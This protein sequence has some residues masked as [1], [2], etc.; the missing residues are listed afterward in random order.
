MAQE[1]SLWYTSGYKVCVREVNAMTIRCEKKTVSGSI[2]AP[3]SK[4]SMQR[5]VA[6]AMLADGRSSLAGGLLS[7]DS[8]AALRIALALGASVEKN[9]GV[10]EI[11]GS[12]LFQYPIYGSSS[13]ES[14][15]TL[16]L[17]CGESGLCMRMF[18]PIAALLSQASVLHGHG[19]L[20]RRPMGMV[21]LP[22]KELGAFCRT[23]E[24]R[25]PLFIRGP[26]RGGSVSID[27][28]ESS[29]LLTGLL[30][31]LPLASENSE[32]NVAHAVSKGYLDLTIDT[33][34]AFGVR[35]EKNRD[36]SRFLIQGKQK[37]RSGEFNVE[38]DWSAA[39]FLIVAA[40]IAAENGELE[41]SGLQNNS[42]Q[43]D[44]AILMAA[45]MAGSAIRI[46]QGKIY[47]QKGGLQAFDF[48]ATDCPDLF[49]PLAVLAA[50]CPGTSI[51]RGIHRLT[52]KESDRA[53]SLKTCLESL[54]VGVT[55]EG[56]SMMVQ[57]GS[58]R[59]GTV[60][61]SGDHRIA[62]AAA[63]AALAAVESVTI[64]GSECVAKSWPGFF[65]DLGSICV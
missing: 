39:S 46:G 5:A 10:I 24:G 6:C 7:D 51:L 23:T 43:P 4:S 42:S 12:A 44:K 35:I 31:A 19:S 28:G 22:L 53:A 64:L 15:G 18:S 9:G 30:I 32:I 25:P 37:Y 8:E 54:G 29:Q 65:G 27:A 1:R 62:M 47:V 16:D 17:D 26:M 63:V 49:P 40:A 45:R 36:Y 56:D 52:G 3:P 34:A 21:E 55:L 14:D 50:A 11:K 33:C 20:A 58:I 38:G 41:I 2:K 48:D 57:G 60:D 61:S 13:Q 59:G